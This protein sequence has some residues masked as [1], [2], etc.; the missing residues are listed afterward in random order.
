MGWV[1]KFVPNSSEG[2]REASGAQAT[3]LPGLVRT[4]ATD[5]LPA[6]PQHQASSPY[7]PAVLKPTRKGKERDASGLESS[8]REEPEGW[9]M[10]SWTRSPRA[11]DELGMDPT[12]LHP[13][14]TP[15]E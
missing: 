3:H 8:L 12:A 7:A 1:E 10:P 15:P 11:S 5:R 2:S 4:A 13:D 9:I 14:D 6:G